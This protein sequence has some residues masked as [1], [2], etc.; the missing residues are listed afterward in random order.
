MPRSTNVWKHESEDAAAAAFMAS[1]PVGSEW[2]CQ[3][4]R[5]MAV[6]AFTLVCGHVPAQG[7]IHSLDSLDV[8]GVVVDEARKCRHELDLYRSNG[9]VAIICR[10]DGV[11]VATVSFTYARARRD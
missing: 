9:I 5:W 1:A 6:L 11:A 8:S 10:E 7:I 2:T 3:I 4:R